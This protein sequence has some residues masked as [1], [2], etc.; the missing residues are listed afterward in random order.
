MT[1]EA[2]HAFFQSGEVHV[3]RTWRDIE[4]LFKIQFKPM[5]IL[6]FG[7]GVGRLVI[8]FARR[9][10]RVVGVDISPAMLA[11]ARCN[12]EKTGVDRVELV[13]SDDSLSRVVGQFELVHSHLV[14]QHIPWK[15]GRHIIAALSGRVA[16]GGVLALQLLTQYQGS[17][18]VR[19]LVKLRYAFPPANWVRNLLF[20]RPLFEPPMQLHVYDLDEI[21]RNLTKIGFECAHIEESLDAFRSTLLYAWRK[22]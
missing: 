9:A 10:D 16:Y 21:K 18:L 17:L 20:G 14:L 8:P 13:E 22:R 11:E 12:V 7:C 2:R 15:R 6:D 3:E 1:P 4:R 5:A 19:G